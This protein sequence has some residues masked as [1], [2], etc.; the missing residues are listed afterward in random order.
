MEVERTNLY[1]KA[2]LSK[3]KW[4]VQVARRLWNLFIRGGGG[5]GCGGGGGTSIEGLHFILAY[6][7][8]GVWCERSLFCLLINT[9]SD[10]V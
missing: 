10:L 2:D 3:Y 5:V 7:A 4:N 6:D 8:Y 9:G 1:S